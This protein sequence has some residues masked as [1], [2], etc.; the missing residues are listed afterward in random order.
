MQMRQT[1]GG[2]PRRPE[3]TGGR[4]LGRGDGCLPR[5]REEGAAGSARRWV[6]S[7]GC[8]WAGPGCLGACAG[9]GG[10][11]PTNPA[12]PPPPPGSWPGNSRP[13]VGVCSL[14]CVNTTL[15]NN[16]ASRGGNVREGLR[17]KLKT[18]P[19][20]KM[21]F[22]DLRPKWSLLGSRFAYLPACWR[23]RALLSRGNATR[24][25]NPR[26]LLRAPKLSPLLAR[27]QPG[28]TRPRPSATSLPPPLTHLHLNKHCPD[29]LPGWERERSNLGE[30]VAG[31]SP[32]VAVGVC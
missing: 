15:T 23:P 14:H 30:E 1:Q 22:W 26:I 16:F 31:Q 18:F 6:R 8:G 2:E 5:G 27:P 21:T 10:R 3:E 4:A 24:A 12:P 19:S 9:G 13:A 17:Y 32:G 7:P 25:W 29:F 11:T 28:V 20:G